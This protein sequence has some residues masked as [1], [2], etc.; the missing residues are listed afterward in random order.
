VVFSF[1]SYELDTELFEL[2][3]DGERR[4]LE[5]QVFDLLLYLVR[6]RD[7]FVSRQELLDELWQGKVVTSSTVSSCVKAARRALGDTGRAQGCIAT[8]SRRGYRFVA[9]VREVEAARGESVRPSLAVLPFSHSGSARVAWLAEMLGDDMSIQLARV[10]GFTVISRN[11]AAAFRDR[12]GEP[13][14]VA[15]ELGVDYVVDGSLWE[16]GERIRVSVQ[17]SD[18]TAAR[19][20]WAERSE[21]AASELTALLSEM[22]QGIVGRLVPEL[23]RYELAALRQRAPVDLDAWALYRRAHATLVLKGWS[24]ESFSEAAA[25][26]RQAITRDHDLALAH[27]YLSLILA[28]GHLIGLVDDDG[29]HDEAVAAGETALALDSQDPDV[30]GY[31]GC[32]LADMGELSRGVTLMRRA[33]DLDPSNAQAH[34]ALGAALLR[35]GDPTGVESMRHGMRISPR[36]SRLGAWGALLARALLSMGRVDQAIEVADHAC[37]CDDKI[38]LPRLVLAVAL[39]A[40]DDAEG[41]R[42]ALEDA[43]R[44]RPNLSLGDI[45]RFANPAEIE[46]LRRAGLLGD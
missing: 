3:C 36:D 44:I 11:S 25:L 43:R 16:T 15:R 29:W 33:L 21:I 40:A 37:R 17:L 6:H 31:V 41:A 5:P 24:E 39:N 20:L 45:S 9:S 27:A 28:M 32:A 19:A 14:R 12:A 4:P 8:A 35:Q 23:H 30:L 18:A 26:L 42:A 46:S 22:V 2:R 13:T 34:A 7:R 1:G 10:P 38:F